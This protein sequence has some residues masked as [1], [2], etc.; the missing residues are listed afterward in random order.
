MTDRIPALL[1]GGFLLV[2]AIS[3]LIGQ[4]RGWMAV[5]KSAQQKELPFLRRRY[6]RRSQ[7]AGMILIIGLMI[8]LGDSLIP[9]E[10]APGT[11][12]VYWMIVLALALWT[13]LLA[14]GDIMSTKMYMTMELNRLHRQEV[15]LKEAAKRLRENN[16]SGPHD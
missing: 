1:F 11:F 12:A 3:M 8:P 4:R 2:T 5:Q 9:W 14:M 15:Q 16:N 13:G 6:R 7:I 10:N